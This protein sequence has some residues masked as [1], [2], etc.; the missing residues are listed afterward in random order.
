MEEKLSL[1]GDLH[2]FLLYEGEGEEHPVRSFE[3][4]LPFSGMMECHGCKD[5]MIPDIQ[6]M[7]GQQDLDIRHDL[8]G[9]ERIV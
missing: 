8:D 7:M 4:T 9:E 2:L 5:G 3:T 1:Q 6:F